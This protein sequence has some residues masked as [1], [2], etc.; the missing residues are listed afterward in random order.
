ML[1]SRKKKK[2]EKKKSVL[3]MMACTGNCVVSSHKYLRSLKSPSFQKLLFP[4]RGDFFFSKSISVQLYYVL[5][6]FLPRVTELFSSLK[7][8]FNNQ[9]SVKFSV[10]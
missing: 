7:L 6:H 3:K 4:A 1:D 5:K 8:L 10:L 2:K 9:L